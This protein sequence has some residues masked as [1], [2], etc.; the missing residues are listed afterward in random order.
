[1]KK[2][3]LLAVVL[4]GCLA[5]PV[6]AK[7][8][9]PLDKLKLYRTK[10]YEIHTDIDDDL[11]KELALRMDVMLE[12]Y[13][14]QLAEY[15][16]PPDQPP[17]TV[18]LF[19]K[20][21]SYMGFTR[22]A[23]TNTGGMFVPGPHPFLTS[24]LEGQGRDE[25]RRTLQHEAFHQFA[26]YAISQDIPTWLNEGLASDF[27]EGIWTGKAF[28]M[29]QIPPRRIRQLQADVKSG[30]LVPFS[31]FLPITPLEWTTTLHADLDKGT[32][33]YN[34]SWAATYY[35]REVER[36]DN[37]N[38][39]VKLLRKLHDGED[40]AT[41]F[42]ETLGKDI[43]GFQNRFETWATGMTASPEA[44]LIERDSAMADLIERLGEKGQ[45][46]RDLLSFRNEVLDK[47]YT[48]NYTTKRMKWTPET[49]SAHF[50][51]DLS[52]RMYSLQDLYFKPVADAP[53]PDIV[54]RAAYQ[55]QVRT[56]F[57]KSETGIE[58]EVLVEP[59]K[60]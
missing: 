21:D 52:N 5:R 26:Y 23:G 17:M 2:V 58:H 51:C 39:Y 14:K 12:Q 11:V 44:T 54:C 30:G 38:R 4:L 49:N 47:G 6:P 3:V 32:M 8:P 33:Y 18:F 25:L 41:A 57:Y 35:L 55:L 7:D 1:M 42:K 48:M 27:E 37:H 43:R 59:I 19:K 40:A 50:F 16:L 28:V 13:Q 60:H 46:F 15:K 29:G 24:F 36:G 9:S 31:K 56:H 20:R 22:L 34:E 45:H 53:F 10:Y